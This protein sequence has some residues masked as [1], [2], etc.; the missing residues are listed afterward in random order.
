MTEISVF[1][2]DDWSV[3]TVVIDGDPWFVARDVCVALGITNG[4][5]ALSRVDADG[6]GT[7]DVIDSL[8]RTQQASIVSEPGLYELIFQS[9]K[10]EAKAFKRWVTHEVLPSIRRTGGYTAMPQTYA[11]ALRE[12]AS[13]V[14]AREAA[15][16]QV[17]A[18]EPSAAAWDHLASA[19]GDYMVG[20][21]A[22]ILSRDPAIQ[23]GQNRLFSRMSEL[24]WVYRARGDNRWRVYQ[25]AVEAGWLAEIPQSHYHP[26]SGQL[27]L[28]SPQVRVTPKGLRELHRR[29]GGTAP[30]ALNRQLS[31]ETR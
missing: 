23:L 20:D 25:D 21:A 3:R 30:L 26:R 2:R 17:K 16:A 4:R 11:A 8:G 18:L 22:K 31:L 5:D 28:D 29:L 7:T 27:V 19:E 6:V 10:P 24:G 9:R 15:E 13:S 1:E 12:L 14:E